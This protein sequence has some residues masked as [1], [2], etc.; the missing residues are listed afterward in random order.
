MN[1][2]TDKERAARYVAKIAGA[3][4]GQGGH[5]FTYHVAATVW[6]GFALSE[7][8]TLD[9]M[10]E[11][12]GRCVPPWTEA[13]L[14]HKVN[15]V[16]NGQ[17]RDLR[18][19]LLG[20]G[21][22]GQGKFRPHPGPLPQERVMPPPPPPKPE[23]SPTVLKRIAARTAAVGDVVAF[24]RER[25]PVV[26][27]TQD[28]ASVLRRLYA[29][30]S[31]ERVLVFSVMESQGQMVWEADR[32]DVIQNRHLPTGPDGI[33]FLPQPVD[34]DYHPNPRQDG[35]ESRRSEE[36]VA[37]WRYAVLESDEADPEDWLRCLVQMP[38]RIACIC[39]SGGRS[40]HAL[41]RVDA[42]SKPDWDRMVASAKPLLITLGADR[43]ALT[44]VRLTRL[45]QA[46]RGERVQRLLYLNPVAD[47]VPILE[48]PARGEVLGLRFKGQ[49]LP[50]HLT[51]AP[52]PL[53]RG[54][55][56]GGEAGAGASS[57]RLSPPEEERGKGTAR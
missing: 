25:S 51:P 27:E 5:D 47:G 44:A 21:D 2:L 26:V 19:Y 32:S 53:R 39:E 57:L 48:Q 40:I 36:S 3:V 17:H 22:R 38:L 6:N 30:G 49:S 33:W 10:L 4:S 16:A 14:V 28:S 42:A 34:G 55:V 18:G 54:E 15:S 11:W 41:V 12:N 9:V 29:F 24:I 31:G 37:A 50:S 35:K 52:L 23:F 13:E 43:G 7:R 8:D 45:P 46:K 1:T 56:Q 20:E